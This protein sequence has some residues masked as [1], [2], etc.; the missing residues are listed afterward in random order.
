MKTKNLPLLTYFLFLTVS[1]VPFIALSQSSPASNTINKDGKSAEE[2]KEKSKLVKE[3]TSR[4]EPVTTT[5]ITPSPAPT[6]D[7]LKNLPKVSSLKDS[8][9]SNTQEYFKKAP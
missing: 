7:P 5:S 6:N 8:E 2:N 1:A 4:I 9:L 3:E